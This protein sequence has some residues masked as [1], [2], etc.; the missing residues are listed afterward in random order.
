LNE[1][2]AFGVGFISAGDE[3]MITSN[4]AFAIEEN[5]CKSPLTVGFDLFEEL[6]AGGFWRRAVR[7]RTSRIAHKRTECSYYKGFLRILVTGQRSNQLN[8]VP[9]E[10]NQ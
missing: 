5:R 8:Y 1:I 4:P 9:A 10:S 3:D 6:Y 2:T 7:V